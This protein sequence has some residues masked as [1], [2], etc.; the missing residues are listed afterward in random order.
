MPDLNNLRPIADNINA[1][2]A[3][4]TR[5]AEVKAKCPWHDDYDVCD[6]YQPCHCACCE[7]GD[8]PICAECGHAEICHPE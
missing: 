8:W 5:R 3:E 2:I 6:G 4:G 1:A 7:N